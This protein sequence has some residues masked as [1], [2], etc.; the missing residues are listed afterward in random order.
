[1]YINDLWD[2]KESADGETTWEKKQRPL[3]TISASNTHNKRGTARLNNLALFC[4]S[5]YWG[6]SFSPRW[7]AGNSEP[8]GP[9]LSTQHLDLELNFP[10]SAT[11]LGSSGIFWQEKECRRENVAQVSKE[12]KGENTLANI[13]K[14]YS[15]SLP[16]GFTWCR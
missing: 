13:I 14:V 11:A 16:L 9:V 10:S 8:V 3:E 12:V 2:N 7:Q 15:G 5:V 6:S 4:W 1:M